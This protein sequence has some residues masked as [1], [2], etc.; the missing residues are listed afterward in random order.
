MNPVAILVNG[1][2]ADCLS[3]LDRGLLYGDGLFETIAVR[4]GRLPHWLR[5]LARLRAGCERL[6]IAMPD[7]DL[8]AAEADGLSRQSQR[9]VLKLVVTRGAGGRGYRPDATATPTRV[10]QLHP[11]PV[12]PVDHAGTGV[13]A[14]VCRVRLGCNPSLAG[15]KHLNRLEQVL[16]R[17]EWDDPAV[18]EGFMLDTHDRLIEGTMSNI[19][20]VTAGRLLTPALTRCGVAG[21]ARARILEQAAAAGIDADVRDIALDELQQADEVL[22]CNSL[23]GIWPVTRV[24]SLDYPVGEVTRLLQARLAK[25]ENEQR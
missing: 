4:N 21:I 13:T 12:W 8:L 24:E 7:A 14:R 9:A 20:L 18:G 3:T 19:F 10:L 6:G 17:A 15:I 5:H 22:L 11:Y 16:A 1:R 25:E 2:A 23:I